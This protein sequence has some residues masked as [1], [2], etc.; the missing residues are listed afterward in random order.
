MTAL[1]YI[2][3]VRENGRW[4]EQGEGPFPLATAERIAR[5]IRK[6][7]HVRAIVLPEGV[8]PKGHCKYEINEP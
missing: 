5:E 4:A 6:D 7:C 8:E 2:V 1:K 3:W